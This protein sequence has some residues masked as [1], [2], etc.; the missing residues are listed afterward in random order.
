M[1]VLNMSGLFV[2]T[3]H[4]VWPKGQIDRLGFEQPV[5]GGEVHGALVL[6]RI[7]DLTGKLDALRVLEERWCTGGANP[8]GLRLQSIPSPALA[9]V[10]LA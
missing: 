10:Q 7:I 9:H 1:W 8:R 2:R 5:G 4:R 3:W 6:A